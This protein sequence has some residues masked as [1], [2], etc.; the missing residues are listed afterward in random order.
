MPAEKC[1]PQP[2]MVVLDSSRCYLCGVEELPL[3]PGEIRSVTSLPQ[4]LFRAEQARLDSGIDPEAFAAEAAFVG[5]A[6]QWAP[7]NRCL[8]DVIQ[9]LRRSSDSTKGRPAFDAC[10]AGLHLT[11]RIRNVSDRPQHFRLALYGLAVTEA[12]RDHWFTEQAPI[13]SELAKRVKSRN[14][15]ITLDSGWCP[16]CSTPPALILPGAVR[17][18]TCCPQVIFRADRAQ[19]VEGISYGAFIAEQAFVGPRM[20]WADAR[21]ATR[22]LSIVLERLRHAGDF[23]PEEAPQIAARGTFDTCNVALVISLYVRNTSSQ[24]QPFKLQLDGQA[25]L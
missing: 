16:G 5:A 11:M 22:A 1:E 3:Q 19:P 15:S 7:G 8:T 9:Q 14:W 2:W 25:V 12:V 20:Q 10:Q 4:V 6:S 24:P 18:V 17:G 21:T 23:L 13:V